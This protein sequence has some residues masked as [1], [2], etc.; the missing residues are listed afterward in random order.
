[1]TP[2][3]QGTDRPVNTR[4]LGVI[5]GSVYDTSSDCRGT[6]LLCKLHFLTVNSALQGGV[7]CP[8]AYC[9]YIVGG[10]VIENLRLPRVTIN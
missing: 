1:M 8:S 10:E 4:A 5:A 9:H 7:T 3:E 2:K 6:V